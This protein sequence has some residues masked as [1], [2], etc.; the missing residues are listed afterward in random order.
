MIG[1]LRYLA[2]TRSCVSAFLTTYRSEIAAFS[3]YEIH[4]NN[5]FLCSENRAYTINDI[6]CSNLKH[7]CNNPIT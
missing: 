3:N 4:S 6:L 2:T 1:I 7:N 5:S